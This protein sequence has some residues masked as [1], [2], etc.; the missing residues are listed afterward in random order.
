MMTVETLHGNTSLLEGTVSYITYL[1][2]K[3]TSELCPFGFVLLTG[4]ANQASYVH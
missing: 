1:Y 2:N 3:D 4:F